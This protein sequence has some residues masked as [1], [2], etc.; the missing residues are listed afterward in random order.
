MR[1]HQVVAF[2]ALSTLCVIAVSAAQEGISRDDA[3]KE[4]L[5]RIPADAISNSQTF[6]TNGFHI[7]SNRHRQLDEEFKPNGDEFAAVSARAPGSFTVAVTK[8]VPPTA[9]HG[10]DIFH[11][12]SG[13]PLLTLVDSDGDGRP[14]V[15]SYTNVD[16]AGIAILQV[17]DYDLDGQPD[18]RINFIDHYTEIWHVGKWYRVEKRDARRGIVLNGSFVELRRENNRDVVP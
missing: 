14:D 13:A 12:D 17:T 8:A 3:F 2:A 15:L 6:D 1:N 5:K 11:G 9:R 16:K 7:E 4:L 18:L 10:V